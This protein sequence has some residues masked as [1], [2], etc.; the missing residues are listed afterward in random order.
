M[1]GQQNVYLYILHDIQTLIL[2]VT[3]KHGTYTHAYKEVLGNTKD[4]FIER[5]PN[6]I[7]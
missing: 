7:L 1:K 6:Y 5:I 2:D 3:F 4:K